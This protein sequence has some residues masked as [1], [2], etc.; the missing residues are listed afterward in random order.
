ES[1]LLEG[2]FQVPID[3]S[4]EKEFRATSAD[5]FDGT[6]PEGSRTQAPGPLKDLRQ[7]QHRH[8]AADTVA[9]IGDVL[10]L[11]GHSLLEAWLSIVQ[12]QC[13]GPAIEVRIAAVR[14]NYRPCWGCDSGVV[15]RLALN[16][17]F[18]SADV[19]FRMLL[20]PGVIRGRMVGNEIEQ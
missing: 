18:C 12:L 8:I 13:I 9:H 16:L 14:Q 2:P 6:R 7:D 19:V 3:L 1:L 5:S 15:L 20:N 11:R 10:Q 17:L 4:H